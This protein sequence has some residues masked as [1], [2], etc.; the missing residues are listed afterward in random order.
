MSKKVNSLKGNTI[1]SSWEGYSIFSD[2]IP[3]LK[4]QYGASFINNYIDEKDIIKYNIAGQ[5]D[6]KDLIL[7]KTPD[8][9]I[10]DNSNS[11]HLD[12]LVDLIDNNYK[13]S[14]CL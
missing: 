14:F 3:I 7:S 8:I 13:K 5:K 6:Y 12:S 1:L 4:E 2:K 9:I 10:Y 11:A